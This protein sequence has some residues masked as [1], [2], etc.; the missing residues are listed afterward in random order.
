MRRRDFIM[1]LG[2]AAVWPPAVRAQKAI[3]VVGM[4][5]SGP[6]EPRRDQLEGFHRGLKEAG[7]VV[8]QNVTIFHLVGRWP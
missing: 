8:G 7:F 4:L 5:N 2:L 6:S 1:T 3:P